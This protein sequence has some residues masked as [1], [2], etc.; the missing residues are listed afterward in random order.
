MCLII[1]KDGLL[2]TLD[3]EVSVSHFWSLDV[4]TPMIVMLISI[5]FY[6]KIIFAKY[7]IFRYIKIS[8]HDNFAYIFIKV[9]SKK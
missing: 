1:H 6:L 5:W 8:D 2:K 9:D 3:D 7:K 4:T